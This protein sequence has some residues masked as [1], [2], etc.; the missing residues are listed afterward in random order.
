MRTTLLTGLA[1]ALGG[2][3]VVFLSSGLDLELEGT[4]LMGAAIGAVLALVPD[5]SPLTRLGGF[6]GGFVAAWIGYLVRAAVL[7]DT[8][9]GRAF[10]LVLV[11]ALC[12]AI[13]A[14]SFGRVPLWAP[15]LGAAAMAGG[16]ETSFAVAPS[17]VVDTSMTAVTTILFTVGVGFLVG[18]L[19][20]PQPA[21]PVK[22]GPTPRTH[23]DDD[24]K[25]DA[26]METSR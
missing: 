10:A 26:L 12:V 20:G 18:A 13:A 9:T 16:Y 7:P 5:R 1:L 17:E 8:T 6:L 14:L 19:A 11:V 23:D 3:I 22:S 21:A 4:A 15:L 24:T 25:L 2:L